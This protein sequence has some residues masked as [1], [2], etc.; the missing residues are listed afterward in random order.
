MALQ[1]GLLGDRLGDLLVTDRV[2][3]AHLHRDHVEERL[4]IGV[5]VLGFGG[6]AFA[7]STCAFLISSYCA[8]ATRLFGS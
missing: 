3:R 2:R 8:S 5:G 6:W 4:V 7:S 1:A